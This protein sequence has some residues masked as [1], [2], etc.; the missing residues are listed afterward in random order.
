M[1]HTT[2]HVE[3]L[4]SSEKFRAWKKPEPAAYRSY[5]MKEPHYTAAEVAEQW[6]VSVDLV[7]DTFRDEPGVLLIERPGT[8]VKRSYATMRI[9]ESVLD[10]V[11]NQLS[12][13]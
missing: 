5:L 4:R 12:K 9:P 1:T 3:I 11:Y 8:R 13:R 6:G 2:D 7:R 10:R